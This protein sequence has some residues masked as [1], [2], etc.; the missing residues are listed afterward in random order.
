LKPSPDSYN[1]QAGIVATKSRCCRQRTVTQAAQAAE[2]PLAHTGHSDQCQGPRNR[3]TGDERGRDR[4]FVTTEPRPITTP[5]VRT[6]SSRDTGRDKQHP[7]GCACMRVERGGVE[8]THSPSLQGTARA[9]P[10][11]STLRCSGWQC[12]HSRHCFSLFLATG[13]ALFIAC[14]TVLHGRNGSCQA[15]AAWEELPGS[16]IRLGRASVQELPGS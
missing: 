1:S 3:E 6:R 11:F 5:F 14:P 13:T 2:S 10:G 15:A 16:W 8:P 7:G 9:L 12:A 4:S